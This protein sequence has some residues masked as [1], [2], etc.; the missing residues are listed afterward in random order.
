MA[1]EPHRGERNDPGSIPAICRKMA[2][3]KGVSADE[4]ARR[5]EENGARLFGI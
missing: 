5:V 4:M 1:P 2:E 3:I